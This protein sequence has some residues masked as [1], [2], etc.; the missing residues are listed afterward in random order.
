MTYPEVVLRGLLTPRWVGYTALLLVAV[1]ACVLLGLWQLGVA[2]DEGLKEAVRSA[3]VLERAPLQDVLDPHAAFTAPLSNRPVTATGT[4]DAARSLV[5]VERRLDGTDGS[6]VVTPLVTADGTVAVLRGLTPGTPT[7]A[8]TP[9]TG[10]VAVDGTL[11]PGESPRTGPALPGEQRRSVDLASLVNEWPGDLYNAVVFASAER[12]DGSVVATDL[13]RVPPP[14]LDAPLNLRNAAYAV[15]WWVFGVFA[16]WMWW[17][18]YRAEQE[19]APETVAP[20]E[21]VPA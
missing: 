16:I 6:W 12:V 10:T 15:Q 2:R 17:K 5:V 20:R 19:G 4:Y 7:T 1:A 3:G 8:P 14:S 9:P 13:Q 21:E 11:G 18:M